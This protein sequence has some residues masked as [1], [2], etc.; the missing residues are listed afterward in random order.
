V[1]ALPTRS[2]M[3]T[4][5]FEPEVITVTS[6]AFE[7]A[8]KALHDGGLSELIRE[9][10]ARRITMAATFGEREPVRLRAAALGGLSSKIE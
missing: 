8:C 2:P 6:E 10:I 3:Q 4:G 9:H 7:A 1:A 5:A